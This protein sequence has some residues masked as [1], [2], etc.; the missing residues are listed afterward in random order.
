MATPP[1]VAGENSVQVVLIPDAQ[2]PQRFFIELENAPRVV[3]AAVD[4]F[5]DKILVVHQA[6]HLG[7]NGLWRSGPLPCCAV[8]KKMEVQ[9]PT[10]VLPEGSQHTPPGDFVER[11]VTVP[12]IAH[13]DTRYFTR[14]ARTQVERDLFDLTRT[15]VAPESF[16][17]YEGTDA[18]RGV[19]SQCFALGGNKVWGRAN[20]VLGAPEFE[21]VQSRHIAVRHISQYYFHP[22]VKDHWA[23]VQYPAKEEVEFM[24]D[25]AR[26]LASEHPTL[27]YDH[28]I[29]TSLG[30]FIVQPGARFFKVDHTAVA[31]ALSQYE[32]IFQ[33]HA[34][35]DFSDRSAEVIGKQFA[36]EASSDFVQ[37]TFTPMVQTPSIVPQSR[38]K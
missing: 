27:V 35:T 36:A 6:I 9:A 32:R 3:S 5:C 7:V 37:I 15:A 1:V 10:V 16:R 8:G 12:L 17:C 20:E 26:A 31:Q 29:V 33:V 30:V 11:D 28:R 25:L 38:N 19:A 22:A 23:G 34:A 2:N 18:A 24:L 21:L 4:I 14:R 13:A